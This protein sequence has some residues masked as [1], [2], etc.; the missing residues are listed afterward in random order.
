MFARHVT[1][2]HCHGRPWKDQH[3]SCELKW[4]FLQWGD[5][6]MQVIVKPP[7]KEQQP[8]ASPWATPLTSAPL[9]SSATLASLPAAPDSLPGAPP[10]ANDSSGAVPSTSGPVP[11]S[12]GAGELLEALKFGCQIMSEGQTN[13]LLSQVRVTTRTTQGPREFSILEE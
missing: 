7:A 9:A 12:Y 1:S 2:H 6:R 5:V 3:A 13:Q 11:E 4:R 10:L 8:S